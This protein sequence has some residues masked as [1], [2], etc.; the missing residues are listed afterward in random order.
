MLLI[1]SL[2][3]PISRCLLARDF[4]RIGKWFVQPCDD[5]QKLGVKSFPMQLS[6]SFAYFVHG[7]STVC[8][9][10]DVRQH[11]S[12]RRITKHHLASCQSPNYNMPGN[13]LI[14]YK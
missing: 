3:N 4:V 5:N 8:M 7:E 9:S 13:Y 1:D 6:L 10:V 11:P 2:S 12:I 14:S